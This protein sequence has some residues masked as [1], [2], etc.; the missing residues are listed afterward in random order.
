MV[1]VPMGR[2][3]YRSKDDRNSPLSHRSY[4]RDVFSS[5]KC[6]DTALTEGSL[7]VILKPI[8]PRLLHQLKDGDRY[9]TLQYAPDVSAP[10]LVLYNVYDLVLSKKI[11]TTLNIQRV[12]HLYECI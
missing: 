10:H 5:G 3:K 12:R 6:T 11:G 9:S 1:K 7:R 2:I 8:I 4:R